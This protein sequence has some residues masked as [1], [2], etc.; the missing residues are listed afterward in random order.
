MKE[1]GRTTKPM[2]KEPICM[3]KEQCTRENGSTTCKKVTEKNSGQTVQNTLENIK[4]AKKMAE[5]SLSG[6]MAHIT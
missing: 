4:K 6:L 2:D 3:P 1:N 5:E